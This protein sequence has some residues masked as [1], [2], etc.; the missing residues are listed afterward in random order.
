[1]KKQLSGTCFRRLCLT[2]AF[3]CC[4][5]G[6]APAAVSAAEEDAAIETLED[7]SVTGFLQADPEQK[8]HWDTVVSGDAG[9]N[10]S[11]EHYFFLPAGTD[12]DTVSIWFA[13]N[14]KDPST[15]AVTN[16]PETGY[17]TI[18][19]EKVKSGDKI[20]LPE[21]KGSL[22]ITLAN[23]KTID[24]RIRKSANVPSMFISTASGS[25]DDIHADKEHKEKGTMLLV[26]ADGAKDFQGALKHIK[27][28]GNVTWEYN[29]RPYN[30]KLDKSADLL[31]MGKAKGW[32][33]IANYLDTSLLR[34]K[35]VYD[36]AEETGID[37]TMDSRSLDLYVN[38]AYK[39][40]Y[41]MTEKVEIDKNRV[42]VTDMEKA[43]E[44]ANGEDA[45]LESYPAG[46]TNEYRENTR[47]WRQIPNDPADITGGYLIELE[48]NIRYAGEAC[49]F[50]TDI[51]QAVTMKAPEFVSKKQI[52][53]IADFY[54]EMEDAVYSATGYNAEGKH[55]SEY[56]DVESVAKM[57]LLQEYSLNLDSGI[58]SFYLYKDSD[59]TGDG[60]FHMA[61]AWDFDVALGNHAGRDGTDLTKPNVWW[62]NQAQIYEIGGLNLLSQAVRHD[63]V[64]RQ[65][66]EQWNETFRPAVLYLLGKET[67][68]RPKKL[69]TL[70]EY[71]KELSVSAE[72]NFKIWPETLAHTV[73]GVQNGRDF[74]ES[75]AYIKNFLTARE[76]F[77]HET[78]AQGFAYGSVSGYQRLT[79]TVRVEGTM[80]VGETLTVHVEN[81]NAQGGF[82]YQWFA[83]GEA[84]SAAD[85]QS[86]V[87]KE[88]DAGKVISVEVRAA[89]DTWLASLTHTASEAVQNADRNVEKNDPA[90]LKASGVTQ[91][92]STADGVVIRFTKTEHAAAYDIF[93]KSG[94]A[95]EK[96]G[97]A[98]AL[99]FTDTK[100]VGGKTVS[101]AVK[102]ISADPAKY[103][104]AEL[105]TEGKITLPKAMKKPKVKAQKGKK[106]QVSWKKVK[107]ASAY[108]IY[109]SDSKNGTYRLIKTIRKQKT[110]RF[111]DSKKIKKNKNYYYK[112]A[113]CRDGMYSPLGTAAK[114]KVKK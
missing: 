77:L 88:T 32:C 109:R 24:V 113:V 40:T 58:T 11:A 76:T 81:S 54:Q 112:I 65:I 19:G 72:L 102:A 49:G 92:N 38:G 79:G 46:G 31:G 67:E 36:L 17:V 60:K 73:I 100:P 69:K 27:G 15:G 74:A 85:A 57:Y 64:K 16:V 1:M 63:A 96:I 44:D 23:G 80:K 111:T 84:L 10:V 59:L 35:I 14:E 56:I 25:L 47:K 50:V 104:D 2:A 3:I 51:G 48:L 42:D 90:V 33:L 101:Y 99:S 8:L 62:A 13:R 37:Y 18:G 41:L 71:E 7:V 20:R 52:D 94:S 70:T 6:F 75:V 86:Y 53:Y 108:L 87:L 30:I 82:T 97:T 98:K 45:D 61:P 89:E 28:R 4:M 21:D 9:Q 110:V 55:Y 5:I 114:V 107:G 43:T 22:S 91:V 105:G 39:G 29:K 66:I 106:V 68:A 34:N 95:W 26:D 83:D 78:P 103:K 12:S 93:R